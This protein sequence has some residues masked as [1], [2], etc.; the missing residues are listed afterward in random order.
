MPRARNTLISLQ[1]TPYYHCVCRCVRR[2]FLWGTDRFSGRDYSHRKQWVVDRLECLSGVFSID[3]CA[4][5]V[6]SNHYHVVLQV[7]EA[8]AQGWSEDTVIARWSTL[9]Q[10]PDLIQRYQD[11]LCLSVAEHAAAKQCIATWRQRLYDISW[12]MRC[13]NEALARRANAEDHCRGRFW[14]GRFTSQALLDEAGLLTCMAYVDLNPVRAGMHP[15]PEASDF[16]AIQ[17]RIRAVQTKST[18][19][20]PLKHF[21][22]PGC[23]DSQTTL[24]FSL[25]DYLELVDW[26]GRCLR[27]DKRGAI[28]EALPGLLTRI[29]IQPEHWQTVMQPRGNVFATAI[30]RIEALRSHAKTLGQ[31]WCRGMSVSQALFSP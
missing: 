19:Q 15:T 27:Q 2:A 16:T 7:D 13:L 30:G 22:M 29:N 28:P 3:V 8:R 12:Y 4:Y 24:P 17:A 14:E 10:R 9:F 23:D 20:V 31:R 21:H 26:T 5:A 25:R 1:D 18:P 6:M 11:G